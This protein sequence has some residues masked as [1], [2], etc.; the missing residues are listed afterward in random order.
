M[1]AGY[2][3]AGEWGLQLIVHLHSE[4]SHNVSNGFL[5]PENLKVVKILPIFD[6]ALLSYSLLYAFW[7]PFCFW[8]DS[9]MSHLNS[10]ASHNV[11]NGFLDP[12][13][14][15]FDINIAYL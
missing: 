8:Q 10:E 2:G 6:T 4:V 15:E 14:V 12:E 13:N 3:Q 1:R 11:S 9:D 5:D 7:Q